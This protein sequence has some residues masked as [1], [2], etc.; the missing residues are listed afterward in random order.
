MHVSAD[1]VLCAGA[2]ICAATAP[3]V[4]EVDGEDLVVVLDANPSSELRD[5]VEA[6][7]LYCPNQALSVS[8][9]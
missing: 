4:F 7:V 8:H 1:R 3:Q 9:A 5:E 2:G 6:A